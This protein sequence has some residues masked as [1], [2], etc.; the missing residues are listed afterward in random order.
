MK[1][2]F[3]LQRRAAPARAH[4]R[5]P[6][7]ANFGGP[8]SPRT[9]G[10]L[11][12][13]EEGAVTVLFAVTASLM[14][15]TLCTAIDTID[16]AQ[17]QARMQMALDVAT[18]S[19][20]ADLSHFKTNTGSDL[21]TW[22]ADARAY[23]DANMPTGYMALTM[24]NAN[25]SATVTG[26]PA[27]GQTI[28]LSASGSVPL[29]APVIWGNN[30]SDGSGSGGGSG[31]SGSGTPTSQTISASNTALRVPKSTLE[32]AL[33]LD[34]TGSMADAAV[35]GGSTSKM[36]GLKTAAA[37]LVTNILGV[38]GNDSYIGLVP[39]TTMVNVGSA[40]NSSGSWMSQVFSKQFAYNTNG[41]SMTQWGGC[42][43]EPH[44]ANGYVYPAYAPKNAPGFTPMYYNVPQSGFTVSTFD[45]TKSCTLQG[46]KTF[47]GVPLTYQT[48]A[49]ASVC[50]SAAATQPQSYMGQVTTKSTSTYSW[51]QNGS[52][53]G[54]NRPCS[55]QPAV[56]FTQDTDKLKVAINNMQ[57]NG[58]TLIPTGLLWGWRML[59]SDWSQDVAGV[60]NG[61]KATDTTLPLAPKRRRACNAW[62]SS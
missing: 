48:N 22:Q 38:A 13:G 51:D 23:Y 28:K 26:S 60:N 61:W 2:G 17:T 37:S 34:N 46:S 45:N 20:G 54:G 4:S 24:A 31:G 36:D 55:I 41:M 32:L 57:A 6:F 3:H 44:D 12:A 14:I 53:A 59:K 49:S 15:G 56:F 25:F 21:A 18:L 5:V 50:P 16:F 62:R 8:S 47:Y 58:S 27:T 7:F 39:F 43:V 33:I 52:D 30:S 29:Y 9:A 42:T 40:L 10:T 35:S 1:R 19:A 11:L